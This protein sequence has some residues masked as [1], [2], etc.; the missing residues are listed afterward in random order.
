M[1]SGSIHFILNRWHSRLAFLLPS[2]LSIHCSLHFGLY[3]LVHLIILIISYNSNRLAHYPLSF[4]CRRWCNAHSNQ[5]KCLRR[6]WMSLTILHSMHW[7]STALQADTPMT[8]SDL[9][10]TS[11]ELSLKSTRNHEH[12]MWTFLVGAV[13]W[14]HV[15]AM[16]R[17]YDSSLVIKILQ[18]YACLTQRTARSLSFCSAQLYHS[19]MLVW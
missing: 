14:H 4:Q 3:I 5:V 15:E 19:V 11:I 9:G 8:P 17:H 1:L 13:P 7:F 10:R 2:R 12:I 16:W 6:I 18:T